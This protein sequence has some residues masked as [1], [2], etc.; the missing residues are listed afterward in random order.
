MINRY[1]FVDWPESQHFDDSDPSYIFP[2]GESAAIFVRE[3][4]YISK[5]TMVRILEGCNM[6]TIH[7]ALERN[8]NGVKDESKKC[9][10]KRKKITKPST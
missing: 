10:S 9:K 7:R 1:I 2:V 3:D 4:H 8:K 5:M 6:D